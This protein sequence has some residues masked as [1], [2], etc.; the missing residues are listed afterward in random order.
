MEIGFQMKSEL[1]QVPTRKPRISVVV[2]ED[3]LAYLEKW[4]DKE[5]RSVSNLALKIIKDAV[6]E[7]EGIAKEE[8]RK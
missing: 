1:I 8:N 7:R 4:A 2:D 6:D 3:L 5:E